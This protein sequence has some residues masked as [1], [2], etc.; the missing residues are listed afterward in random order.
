MH[1]RTQTPPGE[2]ARN[3]QVAIKDMH[4]RGAGLVGASAGFGMYLA[5]LAVRFGFRV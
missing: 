3:L 4:V 5:A 2:G 1:H